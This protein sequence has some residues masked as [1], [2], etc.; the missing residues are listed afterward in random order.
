[1]SELPDGWDK[2]TLSSLVAHDGLLSDGDWVESKDQDPNGS[3]RLLQLA[4]IGDG[5]FL[6]KSQRF[7]NETKFEELRCT[8]LYEGDVLVARMPHPLGRAC[9]MPTLPQRCITVVD[10]TVIRP[11]SNSV[12]SRWLK[13]FLNSPDIRQA[14]DL[15]SSGT[16]RRRISRKNLSQIDL[17][18]PPLNEQ[19]RV[20]DK[21]DV[22][23]T[24]VDACRSRLDRIPLILKRFRQAVLAAATSGQLTEDWRNNHFKELDSNNYNI[25]GKLANFADVIDPNPSHRYPSY[26]GG[27]V[28]LL[29]TE[30]MSG[31]DGWDIS[32]AKLTTSDFYEARKAAHDFLNDD[33]IFARKGRLGLARNPPQNSRY[34]FSHTVFIVRAKADKIFPAY[35]LWFLRQEWCI[36]WLLLEMNSNAGVPTLGKLVMERLPVQIP[37]Y[38]EQQEIVR[39][40]E[41]LFAYGDRI[42]A[43]YH[44]AYVQVERLTPT[45]LAKAFRGELVPQDAN[46]EPASVLLERILTERAAQP[47]KPKR[48]LAP[49][50]PTMT[51]MTEESVKE[52]IR[53]LPKDKFSFDEL[54]ENLPGDYDSLKDILFAL[55]SEGEPSLT[56]VFDREERA[57]RFVRVGK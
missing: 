8:E 2:T 17:P 19:K 22:L 38:I 9:L 1:M 57:M 16:T 45:L 52:A 39:R 24:R 32:S 36:E 13:H 35:L 27:T 23:L 26:E 6:N 37:D 56:Q 30:Q 29:A 41:N 47:A 15:L 28:P 20:A 40:I 50:K 11:G 12:S 34:V 25:S 5:V 42:E 46:D 31:L 48:S 51:K 21:L 55:L 49:K 4:D 43:R 10:V 54:R 18:V 7:I 14:I 53:Q 33:I 3:I 44:S